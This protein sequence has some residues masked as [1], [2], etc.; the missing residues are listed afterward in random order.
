M[1]KRF[2]A[3]AISLS[4]VSQAVLGTGSIS[5]SAESGS[6][7]QS[8]ESENVSTEE[9]L[10]N[11]ESDTEDS[12][13]SDSETAYGSSKK[14]AD[15]QGVED[16][17][18]GLTS[19]ALTDDDSE[20]GVSNEGDTSNGD[21]T[22]ENTQ[23]KASTENASVEDATNDGASN[24]DESN[25]ASDSDTT[26]GAI[27][28]TDSLDEDVQTDEVPELEPINSKY[29]FSISEKDLLVKENVE[30]DMHFMVD[31]DYHL[32]IW[33]K[34]IHR[35]SALDNGINGVSCLNIRAVTIKGTLGDCSRL[36]QGYMFLECVDL[37]FDENGRF[38]SSNVTDTSYMFDGCQMLNSVDISNM[39]MDS[40][41]TNAECMFRVCSMLEYLNMGQLV[42]SDCK[43]VNDIYSGCMSFKDLVTPYDCHEAIDLPKPYY[44]YQDNDYDGIQDYESVAT[45][46]LGGGP[47]HYIPV[48]FRTDLFAEAKLVHAENKGGVGTISLG[49]DKSEFNHDTQEYSHNIC[50]YACGLSTMAYS[51]EIS[52]EQFLID[53]GY[54]TINYY[55]DL[56]GKTA[57]FWIC[58]TELTENGTILV[59]VI[60][61]G[62]DG[63]EWYDNFDAGTALIHEGFE[64]GA[65]EVLSTLRTYLK[66]ND[67][68]GKDIKL[69]VTGHSRAAAVANL[70]G[71]HIDKGECSGF[72]RN[73][74]FVYTFA[75]PNVARTDRTDRENNYNNIYNIVNPEDFVTKV[76]PYAWGYGRFGI[77]YTL[78]SK[79]N[80]NRKEYNTYLK[81]L[82]HTTAICFESGYKYI[83][84]PYGNGVADV[85]NYVNT[86]TAQVGSIY[87][88]TK[89][90]VSSIVEIDI[91]LH[92][93][94]YNTLATYMAGNEYQ[95]IKNFIV[96]DKGGMGY[97]GR[98]TAGF[99]IYQQGIK[100]HF[101]Y[102]HQAETYLGAIYT[103][104]EE[105]LKKVKKTY[106]GI[107][108]CPV[109][110]TVYDENGNIVGQIVNNEVVTSSDDVDMNVNGDSKSFTLPPNS[111]YRVS[112][113]G[114][115]EGT[116]DY[117]IGEYDCDTLM[118]SRIFYNDV[119]ISKGEEYIMEIHEDDNVETFELTDESGS[120][121]D[122]Q[123]IAEDD[124]NSLSVE[125][126]VEGNGFAEGFTNL[127][128]GDYVTLTAEAEEGSVF[129]GWYDETGTLIYSEATYGFSIDKNEKF[130]AKF[131]EASSGNSEESG[132]ENGGNGGN[133][134][135]NT[136]N[137]KPQDN[138]ALEKTNETVNTT[139]DVSAE[140]TVEVGTEFTSAGKEYKVTGEGTVKITGLENKNAKSL[141]IPSSVVYENKAYSVTEINSKAFKGLKKLQKV[142]IPSSITKI[143]SKAFY[144]CSKLKSVTLK[145]NKS[146]TVGKSAFK[147]VNS[148]C[149]IKVK[150]LKKKDKKKVVEKVKKQ[151]NG[152]VK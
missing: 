58:K 47:N 92:D 115:D 3:M 79:S 78:P 29:V 123:F 74:T 96:A 1:K 106:N 81:W 85:M 13:S 102:A 117:S 26:G 39:L 151:T 70:V 91:S 131:K 103:I 82:K 149:S 145:A 4:L 107:I 66:V 125:V 51:D 76:L 98:E 72:G 45:W 27:E 12:S 135:S 101:Q 33:G 36:F 97:L 110:V 140:T 133:E 129:E 87:E 134:S 114:N 69:L 104:T 137:N 130:T 41:I 136:D 142:T 128:Q 14:A 105:D 80:T 7:Y 111:N 139:Q 22:E 89:K 52:N 73:N 9:N 84:E 43:N 28:D 50:R 94:Y 19:E 88:Y 150:G 95:G 112:L 25:E 75:T 54:D 34:N 121:V 46:Y 21:V 40:R 49:I 6:T 147:K 38:D 126:V 37:E 15:E 5:A 48:S 8:E 83:Y 148:D 132:N 57:T 56:D 113:V 16:A 144:G 100:K 146:L 63:K 62:T 141:T 122:N 138:A 35:I 120:V 11:A 67:L 55:P 152:S 44:L 68:T 77:S 24:D 18:E 118:G 30:D 64:R 31:K 127:T 65:Q 116:M 42:F 2:L 143:G 59:N 90:R 86:V 53:S 109:D 17:S 32:Y 93:I 60:I 23:K 10:N 61:R 71:Y 20:D 108:N 119:S 99:F 124:T